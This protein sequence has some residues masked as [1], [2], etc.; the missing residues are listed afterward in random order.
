MVRFGHGLRQVGYKSLSRWGKAA[1]F[2]AGQIKMSLEIQTLDPQSFERSGLQLLNYS[3]RGKE[4]RTEMHRTTA[5]S[6]SR[7]T[8]LLA[9][10]YF[11]F[12][13]HERRHHAFNV[14]AEPSRFLDNGRAGK[15]PA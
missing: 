11:Q 10:F 9:E 3:D 2:M 4:R 6:P 12:F 15:D 8:L 1:M 5:D 13:E 7:T 14:A